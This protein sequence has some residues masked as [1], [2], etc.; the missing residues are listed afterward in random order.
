LMRRF[1]Q[2]DD[3]NSTDIDKQVLQNT[4]GT[5]FW[6]TLPIDV[7]AVTSL[8]EIKH[9]ISGPLTCKRMQ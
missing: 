3:V 8:R 9:Y 4:T 1:T 6:W 2:N 7:G 5:L